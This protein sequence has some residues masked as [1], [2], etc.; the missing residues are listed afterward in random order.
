MLW[1]IWTNKTSCIFEKTCKCPD[2]IGFQALELSNEY[3]FSLITNMFL[4]SRPQVV[5]LPPSDSQVKINVDA[6]WNAQDSLTVV[7]AISRESSD[8]VLTFATWRFPRIDLVF[9]Y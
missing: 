3:S 2:G 5:W 6:A 9:F 1:W 4:V 7:A 8:V